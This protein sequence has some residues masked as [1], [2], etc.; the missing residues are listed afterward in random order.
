MLQ[1]H[2]FQDFDALELLGREV[3]PAVGT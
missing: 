2:L 1:H 3:I